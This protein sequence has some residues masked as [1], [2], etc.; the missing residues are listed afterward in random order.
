MREMSAS[1]LEVV[2]QGKGKEK[3]ERISHPG[4]RESR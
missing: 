3:E 4:V 2:S 1:A